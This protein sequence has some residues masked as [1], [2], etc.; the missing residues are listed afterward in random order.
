MDFSRTVV[1]SVDR[2]NIVINSELQTYIIDPELVQLYIDQQVDKNREYRGVFSTLWSFSAARFHGVIG[3][4]F[5]L[6]IPAIKTNIEIYFKAVSWVFRY[7]FI[8]CIIFILIKLAV[9]SVAGGAICRITALQFAQDEKPGLTEALRFSKDKFLSF[10]ATPIVPIAIIIFIGLFVFLLG[11]LGNIPWLGE[12]VI[13]VFM[14]LALLAVTLIVIITIGAGAGF[15]LMFPAVAYDNADGMDAIGRS[16]S[17]VLSKP[18]WMVF[19]NAIAFVYGAICY[20]F[21]RFF[22]FML[23]RI[24][25]LFVS[26]GLRTQNSEHVNKLAVIWPKPTFMNLLGTSSSVAANWSQST[27]AFIIQLFSLFVIGLVVC[28]IISFYFS[29]NTII[30]SLMRKRIDNV[31]MDQVYSHL[32]DVET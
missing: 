31:E 28:F 10:F 23:L 14:P 24:T 8:Y 7:H 15:N 20:I 13:A 3:G 25:Y 9:I 17:Y 29:A 2:D 6:N 21:V 27:A 19:Y 30:Y 11:L 26:L 32:N 18:W 1:V 16:F 22:A 5:Q 4:L 12:L